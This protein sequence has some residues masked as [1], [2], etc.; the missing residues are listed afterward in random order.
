M[1]EHPFT[2]A[3]QQ[4]VAAA[5]FKAMEAIDFDPANAA[6]IVFSAGA[7]KAR[8]IEDAEGCVYACQR[9]TR[10]KMLETPGE[11]NRQML[12]ELDRRLP[13]HVLIVFVDEEFT[14]MMVVQD[15]NAPGLPKP[16]KAW[17]A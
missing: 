16:G 13:F 5:A 7:I 9:R 4:E 8:G 15:P 2:E 1:S 10:E 11:L 6:L 14:S 3:R 17:E 12:I